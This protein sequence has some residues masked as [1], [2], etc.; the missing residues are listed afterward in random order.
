MSVTGPAT[1]ETL[2]A[3]VS[4]ELRRLRSENARL[5]R[6]LKLSPREAEPPRPGQAGFFEARPGPVHGESPPEAKVAFFGALFAARTDIYAVRW[7]NRRAGKAGWLPAVRGGWRKGVPHSQRD[8]L[9]LTAE[10]LAAHLSG[11]RHIGLYPLLD[12]DRCWWLAADFDGP[13]AIFDALMYLK[14][15]RS[16]GVPAALEVSRS[17]IGAHAWVF[18]TATVP[19]EQA[20]RLGT[21]LLREAMALRGRMNLASYDRLFPSQ[22]LLPAGGVGNL[23]AAPLF[24]PARRDGATVFLDLETLEPH[25]DQWAFLSSLGRMSPRELARAADRAGRVQVGSEVR[26]LASPRS[27]VTHPKAAPVIHAKLSAGI[28]VEQGE[29]T[30]GL[31]ATLRHAASMR[32]PLFDERQRLRAS[33]WGVPRFLHSYNETIDGG[34]ILPRGMAAKVAALAEEAGS[35]LDVTDDRADGTS[36]EFTFTATLTSAQREAADQMTRHEAG[37][38]VAPPGSGKTVIA[39]AVIAAHGV[40]TLVLV[41]RKTLADQWRARVK[42]FLGVKAGQL[43]GG[44]AKLRGTIDIVT[45]QTLARRDDIATLTAGY[46]LVVADECHHVPAAAFED[47]VKQIPARRW[48]GL[49]ATPYRRDKLDDLITWQVGE[50]RHTITPPDEREHSAAGGET[51]LQLDIA[52]GD[53]PGRPAPVLHVHPTTYRYTGDAN[54]SAPGGIATIYRDLAANDDRL[55]QVTADVAAALSRGRHCLVLTQWTTH[56]DR[57]ASALSDMGHEPVVLRGG[58]GAKSRTAALAR[59]QPQPDGPPL[60]AVAT[61]PYAGEGFDCPAL[62]TLFLAAPISFKGRLVQYTGRILRPYPGKTTA[63]VHDY[64]DTAT[65]V[66]AASLA[67]RAPGY[68]S[69]GFPDPRRNHPTPSATGPG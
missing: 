2:P 28:R 12:G 8:Y 29:L 49:T 50:I 45:L 36:H 40:S 58:M 51:A 19:A 24:K 5:L 21:G 27:T 54:P 55:H 61:G 67:K 44:R 56:L 35:R 23:I 59:L 65:P 13:E 57:L 14:A 17:G 64:H 53:E 16:L 62:D 3:T 69:L 6:L 63:E 1:E 68:T 46:G 33:T 11:E 10:V 34:L 43:G 37:V 66:L 26:Q 15:A 7:E 39:C 18:F 41:D 22:D 60:L 47:A 31:A 52:D 25:P 48:L 30:P 4:A 9:P 38:L 42:E 20:R 32:N